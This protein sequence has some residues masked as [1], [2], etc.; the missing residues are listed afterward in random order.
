MPVGARQ[1]G[2]ARMT[3][4][5]YHFAIFGH[6]IACSTWLTQPRDGRA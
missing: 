1:A 6:L 4:V 3:F 2:K 5:S